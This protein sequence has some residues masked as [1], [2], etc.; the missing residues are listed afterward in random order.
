MLT[1]KHSRPVTAATGKYASEPAERSNEGNAERAHDKALG[2]P[3]PGITGRHTLS[4][5]IV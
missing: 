2:R 3:H 5:G 4:M 1:G